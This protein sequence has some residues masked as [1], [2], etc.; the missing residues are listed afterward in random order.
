MCPKMFFYKKFATC[1]RNGSFGVFWCKHSQKL[2]GDKSN[3]HSHVP[4]QK[5]ILPKTQGWSF[6]GKAS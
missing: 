5:V 1:P 2:L 3:L 4:T 6:M